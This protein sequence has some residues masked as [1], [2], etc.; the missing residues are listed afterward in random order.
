MLLKGSPEYSMA[1]LHTITTAQPAQEQGDADH[2]HPLTDRRCST[3]QPRKFVSQMTPWA[4][5]VASVPFEVVIEDISGDGVGL[6]HGEALALGMR[7]QLTVPL[8][9]DAT[10][11]REYIV[12]RCA[13]RDDGNFTIGLEH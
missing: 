8:C 9:D 7:Y 4:P 5:G 2:T 3:R 13:P 6:V 10:A 11:M 12:V 1:T